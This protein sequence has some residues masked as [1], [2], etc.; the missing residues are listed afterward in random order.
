MNRERERSAA[1]SPSR[2]RPPRGGGPRDA[3]N[4]RPSVDF[5]RTRRRCPWAGRRRGEARRSTQPQVDGVLLG[6]GGGRE[7]RGG[8]GAGLSFPEREGG[9]GDGRGR[10]L[11]GYYV[12]VISDYT[13]THWSL[14]TKPSPSLESSRFK[15]RRVLSRE[16]PRARPRHVPLVRASAWLGL[17]L[18]GGRG[19]L[20]VEGCVCVCVC[21]DSRWGGGG[22]RGRNSHAWIGVWG[23]RVSDGCPTPR[24]RG[25]ATD[26]LTCTVRP[27][28]RN[29][30]RLRAG[31]CPLQ[32]RCLHF[33]SHTLIV[34]PAPWPGK[35]F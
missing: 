24:L 25:G 2:S 35:H 15:L 31:A 16:R 6:D 8:Q 7:L 13:H 18:T 33:L 17:R 4:G 3:A 19:A 27:G 22:S 9:G 26:S 12:V 29:R 1:P 34:G 21:E 5:P 30:V 10:E 28:S 11:T 14:F 20:C 23:A 32:P